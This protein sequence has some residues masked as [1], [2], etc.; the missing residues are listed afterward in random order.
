[1]G[2]RDEREGRVEIFL[3][4]EWGTI[5]EDLWGD[6]QTIVVCRQLGFY[7]EGQSMHAMRV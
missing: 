3:N 5:C 1:M 6:T 2:G 4:E 7:Q